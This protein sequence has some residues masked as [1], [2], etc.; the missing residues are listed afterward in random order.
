MGICTSSQKQ[1]KNEVPMASNTRMYSYS[2]RDNKLHWRSLKTP[3]IGFLEM[4][5]EFTFRAKSIWCELPNG[6]LLFTG[7]EMPAISG[8]WEICGE[9]NVAM[10]ANMLTARCGH[11]LL[12]VGNLVYA[13]SG[14]VN[15]D[16]TTSLCEV[17]NTTSD[18]WSFISPIPHPTAQFTPVAIE[19]ANTLYVVG[20][21]QANHLVQTYNMFNYRWTEIKVRLP[22]DPIG[23]VPCFK[24]PRANAESSIYF[25]QGKTLYK[26][27]LTSHEITTKENLTKA[28]I[29]YGGPC[30]VMGMTLY[31][32]S[33]IGELVTY[34]FNDLL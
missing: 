14:L 6:H 8:V 13:I 12:A 22:G 5:P 3:D 1:Q 10:K 7:G 9:L 25:I 33:T 26:L 2:S 11:G 15:S 31:C 20:G 32:S 24:S 19:S 21:Y 34:T 29:C 27:D 18:A 23:G 28:V 4:P 17:Y 30:I 16:E